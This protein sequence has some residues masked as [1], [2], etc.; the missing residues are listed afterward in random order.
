[1]HSRYEKIVL[2]STPVFRG[3]GL[4]VNNCAKNTQNE[5]KKTKSKICTIIFSINNSFKINGMI[6]FSGL[7]DR[8]LSVYRGDILRKPMATHDGSTMR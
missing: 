4:P 2:I 3:G 7:T 6:K 8:D 1:M 5:Q